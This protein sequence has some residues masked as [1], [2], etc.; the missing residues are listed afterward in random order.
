MP[1]EG[2][3]AFSTQDFQHN[4]GCAEETPNKNTHTYLLLP[5]V[6]LDIGAVRNG[7]PTLQSGF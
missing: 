4:A 5:S 6:S 2:L 7:Q 1:L 3:A